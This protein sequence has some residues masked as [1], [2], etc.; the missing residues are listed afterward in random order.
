MPELASVLPLTIIIGTICVGAGPRSVSSVLL[1]EAVLLSVS[2]V[3]GLSLCCLLEVASVVGCSGSTTT[4]LASVLP[5]TIIVVTI[6]VE[7]EPRSVSSA[8][9]AEA[10]LLSIWE[11]PAVEGYL[12]LG[13][14]GNG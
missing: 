7:A 11:L 3:E 14:V 2:V 4:E 6:C 8:S 9:L 12:R 13:S 10:V 5:L 1:A